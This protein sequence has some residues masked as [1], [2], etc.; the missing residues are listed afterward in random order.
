MSMNIITSIAAA[1][2]ATATI[3]YMFWAKAQED[4][5]AR[6]QFNQYQANNPNAPPMDA[7]YVWDP[8]TQQ[9]VP[10]TAQY[11]QYQQPQPPHGQ[12][13]GRPQPMYHGMPMFNTY[14]N[15]GEPNINYVW[16]PTTGRYIPEHMNYAWDPTTGRYTLQPMN[17][18][19]YYQ[20]YDP[21][22]A[23]SRRYMTHVDMN[24][25]RLQQVGQ[26]ID[27]YTMI[28]SPMP[29]E[30]SVVDS[31][32]AREGCNELPSGQR[33][34][35]D[36]HDWDVPAYRDRDNGR[37]YT[38]TY[39]THNFMC[40]PSKYVENE[41]YYLQPKQRLVRFNPNI[42]TETGN[43]YNR[44]VGIPLV[45]RYGNDDY[46]INDGLRKQTEKL[47]VYYTPTQEAQLNGQ[48]LPTQLSPN[49]LKYDKSSLPYISPEE[50][51]EYMAHLKSKQML[52][53]T[54]MSK[55]TTEDCKRKPLKLKHSYVWDSNSGSYS[56]DSYYIW[57]TKLGVYT[58]R[59]LSLCSN[60]AEY[61]LGLLYC[62]N[63]KQMSKYEFLM[64]LSDEEFGKWLRKEESKKDLSKIKSEINY[65]PNGLDK[66]GFVGYS[67]HGERCAPENGGPNLS[68]Y[69]MLNDMPDPR[70]KIIIYNQARDPKP[71]I[72]REGIPLDP[73]KLGQYW[74]DNGEAMN[75]GH[76]YGDPTRPATPVCT[77]MPRPRES[78]DANKYNAYFI[79]GGGLHFS[80]QD[81]VYE[82]RYRNLYSKPE[83]DPL[84]S[85]CPFDFETKTDLYH[86]RMAIFKKYQYDPYPFASVD[87]FWREDV[88]NRDYFIMGHENDCSY[89][90]AKVA[91]FRW[92]R[93][94]KEKEQMRIERTMREKKCRR[95]FFIDRQLGIHNI[96]FCPL[97]PTEYISPTYYEDANGM[98]HRNPNAIDSDY[99]NVP[100]NAPRGKFYE[101]N[102]NLY[103][104]KYLN[105]AVLDTINLVAPQTNAE[106][107]DYFGQ[108]V[109]RR[110]THT[111]RTVVN[112]DIKHV[113]VNYN[114][115][116]PEFTPVENNQISNK[117]MAEYTFNNKI[118]P[119][120]CANWEKG[121]NNPPWFDD[122]KFWANV[123]GDALLP[124]EEKRMRQEYPLIIDSRINE[125]MIL[126]EQTLV[127]TA[128]TENDPFAEVFNVPSY[129][130]YAREINNLLNRAQA[131]R[132]F[133]YTGDPEL[134]RQRIWYF[135]YARDNMTDLEK[136]EML[137]DRMD[138]R[139]HD[140]N[141]D[142]YKPSKED[143][144][145]DNEKLRILMFNVGPGLDTDPYARINQV[146]SKTWVNVYEDVDRLYDAWE[147]KHFAVNYPK[148]HRNPKDQKF[149]DYIE[150][151]CLQRYAIPE[152]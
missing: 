38:K 68:N 87:D 129:Y 94:E 146:I 145:S 74:V 69:P 70:K 26:Q 24:K 120:V 20:Q 99:Y 141:Y 52:G 41:Y 37:E 40:L 9:Y 91:H 126:S 8:Y 4:K 36:Y 93:Q 133:R 152:R 121:Q 61:L 106:P 114:P 73:Q 33:E 101:S 31:V 21:T 45:R 58:P 119:S 34:V 10:Q 92:Y 150:E 14:G 76:S 140:E 132:G 57:N 111:P 103:A 104:N 46:H 1:I 50:K 5:A 142:P 113:W 39:D 86:W 60:R 25:A 72:K 55:S 81:Y 115:V 134:D 84:T 95:Q 71:L 96:R 102:K 44:P 107:I 47:G 29:G 122:H 64:S 59:Y 42:T 54:T 109:R 100:A 125:N 123:K 43:W 78:S 49:A 143:G 7:M 80:Y 139:L 110:P 136:I 23:S 112:N 148:L 11:Q 28:V 12:Y 65:N 51:L 89:E 124:Y 15:Y 135:K 98:M 147:K 18:A 138:E 82:L 105:E 6:E 22:M 97:D 67:G 85:I 27:P 88:L 16:D 79:D 130:P 151:K 32:A 53:N 137:M 17:E 63:G 149:N 117:Q 75:A 13:Y 116:Y 3:V 118:D 35:I 144:L 48:V 19:E 56:L 131:P 2:V 108:N 128:G 62:N 90:L 127:N 77:H 83:D 66:N 30:I